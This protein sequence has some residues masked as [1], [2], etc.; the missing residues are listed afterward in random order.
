PPADFGAAHACGIVLGHLCRDAESDAMDT[1]RD[2]R[3]TQNLGD[4]GVPTT[5]LPCDGSLCHPGRVIGANLRGVQHQGAMVR[6][7]VPRAASGAAPVS[8]T[9]EPGAEM[10]A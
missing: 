2:P 5:V 7:G 8:E 10:V 9:S 1:R 4:A 3:L 6:L